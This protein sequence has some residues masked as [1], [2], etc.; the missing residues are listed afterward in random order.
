[1]LLEDEKLLPWNQG[2]QGGVKMQISLS[3]PPLL[4]SLSSLCST[5]LP[6]CRE[7]VYNKKNKTLLPFYQGRQGGVKEQRQNGAHKHSP[8]FIVELT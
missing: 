1:L 7:R 5:S 8:P 2:R 4:P 6:K 3:C